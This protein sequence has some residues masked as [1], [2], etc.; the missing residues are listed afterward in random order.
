MTT[1]QWERENQDTL[2]EYFI[3]VA[4]YASGGTG[5]GGRCKR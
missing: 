5:H 2:L 1:E 4:P 3:E